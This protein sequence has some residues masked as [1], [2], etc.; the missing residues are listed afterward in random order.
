M[1]GLAARY[2]A[3]LYALADERK[4]LDSVAGDLKSL[5]G[6]IDD[7]PDFRRVI[8][9]PVLERGEQ[10]KAVIAIAERA[11]LNKLTA[12]FLGLLAR[13]RRLFALPTM[14][15]GYLAILAARRG[16]VTAEIVAAQELSPAQRKAIDARL[17]AAVPLRGDT[18]TDQ[19]RG[20]QRGDRRHRQDDAP[21]VG[22]GER[23]RGPR[24]AHCRRTIPGGH[25]R[26]RHDRV[27]PWHP[28]HLGSPP[29]LGAPGIPPA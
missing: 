27:A 4:A 25:A 6:L 2:A 12:N 3:A 5:R 17:R 23:L 22:A 28:A 18:H 15:S 26:G 10:G 8:R 14:I 24:S 21:T 13:N 7:S 16:E 29:E 9:S 19:P 20:S 11:K 1:A